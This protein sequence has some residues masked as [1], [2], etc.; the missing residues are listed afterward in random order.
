MYNSSREGQS[1]NKWCQLVF[2]VGNLELNTSLTTYRIHLEKNIFMA[3]CL[4]GQ[5]DF[6]SKAQTS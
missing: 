1:L 6:L 2:Q 5:K 4:K 3:Q